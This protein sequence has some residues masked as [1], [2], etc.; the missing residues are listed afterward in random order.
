MVYKVIVADDE[1][2]GLNHICL[3]LEKNCPDYKVIGKANHGE[4]A[5]KLIEQEQPDVLITDVSMPVMDGIVLVSK[6]KEKYPEILSVI[7][8]GYSEFEYAQKALKAGVCDYLLKPLMPADMENVM[9]RLTVIIG[10]LYYQKRNQILKQL[11]QGM[12]QKKEQLQRYFPDGQYFSVLI[13]KNSL[14]KRFSHKTGVEIFG[15]EE[16]KVYIY[17]RDEMEALY[18]YPKELLLKEDIR[19][20]AERLFCK[21][22]DPYSF[23][24]VVAN[25]DSFELSE[26][27]EVAKVLYRRLDESIVIG[28]NQLQ[29][30]DVSDTAI[31][32]EIEAGQ[33]VLDK[34]LMDNVE[35]IIRYREYSKI[36]DA[37]NQLF[38]LWQQNKYRQLYVES[39]VKYLL[40]LLYNIWN[41]NQD[42]VEVDYL[43]DDAFYYAT[44]MEELKESVLSIINLS[45]SFFGYDRYD[46]E[47]RLFQSIISY[48]YAHMEEPLTIGILC[49]EFGVSQSIL[50][51]MFRTYED[52]SFRNYL[53]GI[54]IDRA[55]N[56]MKNDTYM[57]IK[58]IAERVGYV[59]Q[60]YFS[61][62]FRSVTGMSPREYLDKV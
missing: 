33:E 14:P 22:Q 52:T 26:L 10:N 38:I 43:V 2:T 8:S 56:L 6:V 48:L 62:V 42:V 37:L 20:T 39:K 36:N 5:L 16:E 30:I 51:K 21:Y 49:R 7:V 60:F 40:N 59:D 15:M 9:Q 50:S 11:C 55:K 44:T 58:D 47:E 34:S 13:R 46:D 18:V 19:M 17:G 57:Y 41:N 25:M 31:T 29:F 3:I 27:S 23:V 45:I 53:T 28:E 1:P 35:N 24:T 54:R 32:K 4:E 61:R 12:Q